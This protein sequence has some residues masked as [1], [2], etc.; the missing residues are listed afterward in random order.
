[1]A[2]ALSTLGKNSSGLVG[3]AISLSL[4]PPAVNA[5]ICWMIAFLE[6][7]GLLDKES[8]DDTNYWRVG[9][10]SFGLTLTNIVCIW[11]A[12]VFTFW[13]KEVAPI[14]QKSA[15]WARDLKIA[16]QKPKEPGTGKIKAGLQAAADL[17]LKYDADM[18]QKDKEPQNFRALRTH[19]PSSTSKWD[20]A[21]LFDRG[22]MIPG[23]RIQRSSSEGILEQTEAM[24]GIDSASQV[25]FNNHL[26]ENDEPPSRNSLNMSYHPDVPPEDVFDEMLWQRRR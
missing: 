3:V 13:L 24:G 10:I 17:K 7:V 6:S 8:D 1:M 19:R 25:L 11:L 16:R 21:L 9:S 15:F 4:L 12:G 26:F 18:G 14:Q 22:D 5:G 2:T 23:Q 20:D